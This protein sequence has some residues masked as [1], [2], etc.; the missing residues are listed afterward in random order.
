MNLILNLLWF[1]LGGVWMGLAWVLAGV[2]MVITVVGIPWAR[3]AFSIASFSFW[4]F[5]RMAVDRRLLTGR[6]DIG[7]GAL[8]VV[9]NIVWFLLAG[10][11][12]A[13]GHLATALALAV[14]I[15]GI[16][17]AFQ[18]IKL[19]LLAVAPIGQEIVP[20]GIRRL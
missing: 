13:L 14:T 7:T 4:P 11:W 18:H 3:A 5:G 1:I 20:A 17:F 10:W 16:P 19:A 15:I 9:G 12:L 6:D 8:G 2:V